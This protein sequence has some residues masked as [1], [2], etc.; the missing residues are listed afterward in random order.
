MSNRLKVGGA[1]VVAVALAASSAAAY[2]GN[3]TGSDGGNTATVGVSSSSSS[4][5]HSGGVAPQSSGRG[6]GPSCTYVP[7]ELAASA[8]FDLSPGGP[9]PG[10]WFLV[11][12]AG[13]AGVEEVQWIPTGASTPAVAPANASGPGDA[14]AQAAA[15]IHLESPSIQVNPAEFSLVNLPTWLALDPDEW[16]ADQASATVGGITATAVATPETVSWSMGDGGE[17]NCVGPGAE[18]DPNLAASVQSTSCSYTYRRSSSGEPSSDGNPNDGAFAVTAT[19]MWRVTWTA[20][21]APGGGALPPL[22]TRSTTA[23]RV[24][25]VESVGV[26]P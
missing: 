25:Q 5:G 24:E 19:V 23:I 10:N 16:H 18:F 2:T 11:K 20:V 17:E 8:G 7:V 14:A 12:C 9:K 22:H 26:A 4:P 13:S 6:I 21:G 1:V 3:A 15:S